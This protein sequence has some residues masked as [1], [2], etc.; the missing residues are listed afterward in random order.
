MLGAVWLVAT[1]ACEG[2]GSAPV[3]QRPEGYRA[4]LATHKVQL[5]AEQAEQLEQR[6][7]QAQVIADYGAFKVVQVDEAAL[8]SLPEGAEPRD[9]SNDILLNAGVIDTASAHGQSLRG[10]KRQASGKGFHLVQFAGPIKPEWIKD[11]EA[12][13]VRLVTYIPN[14]AYLVY[15]D[16]SALSSMQRR[17]TLNRSIQWDGAY[18]DDYKLN[19]ALNTVQTET[20]AIQLIKD[21]EV[22]GPT[23]ELIRSKQ[24]RDGTIQEALGY[25]NVTAY[26]TVKDLY[27]IAARP[28]VLSIMPRPTPKK[29]DERQDMILAGQLTGSGP[30]GP[31]YLAWLASKGFTQ[32]QFTASGFGVDVSDSGMDNGTQ[33]PNHFGLYLSGDVTSPSRVVYNR[34]EGTANAGSTMQGCDGH[35]NLNTHIIAGYS[36]V[37]GTPFTDGAG[38]SYGLGVA[39]FVKVGSSVV[40]DPGNFT[41]PNYEN[42][43]SRAYRDGMR[44][45]SNSWGANTNVYDADAQR[46]DALVRD[47]QPAT[48]AVPAA[49]NQEMVIVFAAGNSGPAANTVGSPGTAKNII[50]VGASENVQAFGGS[51]QCAVP[52]AEA[53]KL[54]DMEAFSSRGP[55]SDGRKKPDIVAPGTHISGGV[56]QVDTQR[57]PSPANPTGQALSCFDG[58]GVCG[59]VGSNF[60]PAGQQWYTASSGTSHATPAVSGG[61][62]L[63]RQYFLNQGFTPPSAAMTKAYLMNSARYMTGVGANDNLWSNGQGMGLMDLGRAFDGTS[64]LLDDENPASLFTATGQTRTFTGVVSDTTKPFRVTLGW[65]DAPGSTTGNAWKNNLDLTVTVGGNTYKGNVFT[66]GVS[67]PGGVADGSNNVES[68]FLL[69]GVEGAYTVTVTAANIN[70]DGVPGNGS[71]LDQDFALVAYNSC[72]TAT[73]VPTGVSATASGNNRVDVSWAANGAT[74]YNIYRSTTAGGPYTRVGTAVSSPFTDSTVSGGA[75]YYYV[76]RA[77]N[78]AESAKSTEV[79]VTAS[80]VCTLPPTFAGLTSAA[81]SAASTCANT[82]TWPAATPIC[83]GTLSYSVYRSTTAGFT[84]SAANRVATGVTGTSFNDDLNLTSAT[85]YYYVVRATETSTGVNEDS[86]TV[87]KSA[88]PTGTVTPGVRYFDD[89]DAN[90]PVNAASYWIATTQSGTAGTMNITTSCHYQS[91]TKS[92]RFGAASTACGGAYP[93]STQ[94]T[95]SLGGNGTTAGINGFA[96]PASTINPQMTFNIWYAF[97]D[98]WDG[99]WLVYS[100]TGATGPWTPVSDTASTTVPY[101]SAGG[102]DNVLKS[103]TTT[104]IWTNLNQGANGSLKA[105]TVNLSA[106][107]G[108]TVWFGFK[109]Y[110]DVSTTAEG[111]YLDDVRVTADAYSTCSTR[112]PPPGPAVAYKV[113]GLPASIAAG[114]A[115]TVTVT[116]VDSAGVKAT[117]YSGTAAVT[118]SDP[119]AV[120]PANLTFSAGVA[121]GSVTFGK[122]GA[123][124]LTATDTSN[125]ALTSS[126]STT[127]TVGP[128]SQLLIT[129]QPSNTVAAASISPAV[130][131][132]LADAFGNP[133]TTGTN[134]VTLV[135]GANP[136]GGTLSG[137]TTATMAAGVAT[138]SNLSINKAGAGYTLVAS[139][140]GLTSAASSAFNITPGAASKLAFLTQPSNTGAGAAI[141]PA[142]QVAIVDA[143][144]NA[145]ASTANVTLALGTNPSSGTLG[146]TTT[147]AAVGGVATFSNLTLNRPGTGYTLS[148]TSTGLTSAAS[149]AFTIVPGAPYRAAI[150]RQPTNTVA[151]ATITPSVQVTLLDSAGN[152]STQATNAVSVSIGN[153]PAGGTLSGTTTVN[154]VNGVAT[155][156]NLSVDRVGFNYTLVAGGSGLYADSSVGFDVAVGAAAQLSFTASPSANVVSDAP[157]TVK[158]AVR[159][160]GGNL[161]TGASAPV[162]LALSNA[163][164]ATLNGTKVAAPVNGVATF[165]GLSVDKAGSGYQ[166][167]ATATGLTSAASPAFGVDPGAAAQVAFLT[168]PSGVTSGAAITP[169]VRVEVRDA[170]GNRVSGSGDGITVQLGSN[171]AGG[172]LSGTKTAFSINGVATF[173]DLS[174]DKAG[175]G[176]TLQAAFGSVHVDS[177]SFD[178]APGSAARLVFRT[179]PAN[180]AAG[181]VLGAVAVEVQ[182]SRGNLVTNSTA[183]VTLTLGGAS[184]GTLGGTT[185]VAA[186]NGVATFADL[187]IQKAATGYTVTA[188]STGLQGSTSGAFDIVPGMAAALAFNAQPSKA[189]AGASIAPA[190]K[191]SILDAY[192]NF[193]PSATDSI[194]LALEANASGGTLGGITT[195]AAVN[196]VATFDSL[197]I[198]RAGIGY[199]LDA[200]SGALMGATST[201]FDVQAGSPAQLVFV[202]AP[203]STK[204]GA[205][206]GTA[207]VEIR[208]AHGNLTTST[209]SVTLALQGPQGVTLGG[210]TTVAAVGGVATFNDLSVARVGTG[211]Q[212]VAHA[213]GLTDA[214]S[215]AFDITHGPAAALVFTVQPGPAQAG[216]AIN[217][218]VQVTLQDAFGNVATSVTDAVTVAIGN[219]PRNG[220]LSGTKTVNAINGVAT[221]ADLSIQKATTGYTLVASATGLQDGTS[222]GFDITPAAAATLAFSTR[223][224]NAVA[225]ASIAPAVK[226]SILDA[227]GNFIPSATDSVTLALEA[228]ASGGTLGGIT[229]AAAINGVATFDSLTINRAGIGYKLDAM[230]GALMGATSTTFDVQAGSPAQLVFVL[231]PTSTKAGAN[232]GTVSVEI[233][234]AHGNLTNSTTSVTLALQGPQGGTLGGTTTVAAVGGVATFNDLSV[235]RVGTGYQLVARANGLTD[236]TSTAFDITH[237]PAAA[238]VFTVQPGSAQAGTVISPA[239]Q[240]TLQDAFGNVATSVT[241]AVT[242]AIGNNP[243][244]GTLSGT[245]TVNAINGVA[246]FAD[247]SIN[248]NGKGYTLQA[249]SGSLTAATSAVF[250]ITPGKAPKLVFRTTVEQVTAGDALPSIEVELRDELDN[251]ITES[252][253]TVTLGLGANSAAGQLLGV[254]TAPVV[255]GVAR[256]DGLSLRKAGNGYTLVASAPGFAGVTST[257]FTVQ[258][259]AAASYTLALVSSVTAGQEATLSATA[260]DAYGNL[261]A[262]YGGSVKVTSSDA[263]A[264]YSANAQFVEGVLQGF[265]VTFK[266]PGLR[267]L[268]V[269]DSEEATLTSTAL[270]N[271]TPFAQPTAAVTDPAGGTTV[272]GK[273]NISAT[274]AVAPGTTLARL[275][276]LVDGVEIASGSDATVTGS[277]DS[278]KAQAGSHI[279]TALVTDGAGN[280]AASAPV[281]VSVEAGCGCGATSNT[282]AGVYLGLLVLAWYVLG[283]RRAKAA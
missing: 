155:F 247:L 264:T 10:M 59:G 6:G 115:A 34:L 192:G 14:N 262:S 147:V 212:L 280:M 255:N 53:D 226:V 106:L 116:A 193:I 253:T 129:T 258:P 238:L 167:Q 68:V 197:T 252:V 60:Y 234:D 198:N 233:R 265:K 51:D 215:T 24:S 138:F 162:T 47:A 93:V 84:P 97:E 140:T 57:S 17:V 213:N 154:A 131:V 184:G 4:G 281:V 145:T 211:Y 203:T 123:Q 126:A 75:T 196:G 37:T 189:V 130:K 200:M 66:G 137:T 35:G 135:L 113:T 74:S 80:G 58:S 31:G 27:E 107:A 92:Y 108:Q 39:P 69:A 254:I 279:I 261:A 22:N 119:Q 94:A 104:R 101:V 25:V 139:S 191:V 61:A 48:A 134:S 224:G 49:G 209:T 273:V 185:T 179:P 269:T 248:R 32:Q 30:T 118:S 52:D 276:I 21:E 260:Y 125:A 194:T 173:T 42:L 26:L 8:A 38:F 214:T 158:V 195:V 156:A 229:T 283:R 63:V 16:V 220:T 237:G 54:S 28:D 40:F 230:S 9:D 13:G 245:K 152:V 208:D 18:L 180:A 102:Y 100:T 244:N 7:V 3:A 178:V 199:K 277:W 81:N 62:A 29:L 149:A 250:D 127:V 259:G 114:T 128:A 163:P 72:T 73:A 160:A 150:T 15:G 124:T 164:G 204:A 263:T 169:A 141:T 142:V 143:Q 256:F 1:M 85:T 46:Y 177:T 67:A 225:G 19:P 243:R 207:S 45:S 205:N 120:L 55:T 176:Y 121:A 190:V 161:V 91:A 153:N 232:L 83:G 56:A 157:F 122:V 78:C 79:S 136:G 216:T 165:M 99:A 71:T 86:N 202:L 12:T 186:I 235:A 77:V 111:F 236:A 148:A 240:V 183:Q 168:Q 270:L 172:T 146:G 76:V 201:T 109:F 187:F 268:T 181:A 227:Y 272:S 206:L 166:L 23:L 44:I 271:V 218:A 11:L 112:T 20:Y 33:V 70:S 210:T 103:S 96:V 117:S 132:G 241:D 41:S 239:I 105:V 188:G 231:A 219:N 159:D 222:G 217:P 257:A 95:L 174:L 278:S 175:T 249:S 87:Q 242:V 65:T 267:S 36:S 170:A 275:S 151:G 182:D 246:T 144:G 2:S 82:L 89:L 64:R 171:P 98:Q 228:N 110:S 43:Q 221:F 223:P 274:G 266:S 251:V 5:S 90:R 133:V 88:V 50:T 282:E